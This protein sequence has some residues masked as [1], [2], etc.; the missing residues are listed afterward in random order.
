MKR[1]A[2]YS[3]TLRRLTILAALV[4]VCLLLV[5]LLLRDCSA[6]SI[7]VEQQTEIGI[8]PE[9]IR[10][11]RDIGQWEFL[12]VSDEEFVDTTRRRFTGTDRLARIYYGTMRIGIDLADLPDDWIENRGDTLFVTLPPVRLLDE[13]FIDEA[14]TVS[15]YESGR[16]KPADREA[17]Y[18]RARQRMLRFGLSPENIKTAQENALTQFRQLLRAMGFEHVEI[19]F[20]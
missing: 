19:S 11:I 18:E 9:Q 20:Q 4:V 17:M 12:S 15:F 16:W 1:Y 14:R 6:S 13:Q 8:T 5:G 7:S 2:T 10:S 3:P